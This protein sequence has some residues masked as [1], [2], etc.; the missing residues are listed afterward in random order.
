MTQPALFALFQKRI[1][2]DDSLLTLAQRLFQECGLL[3]EIHAG[4]PEEYQAMLAFH[5]FPG[6]EAMVHL[7]RDLDLLDTDDRDGIVNLAAEGAETIRGLVV[8]DQKAAR[9]NFEAY[10]DAL[11]DL[12]R[13]LLRKKTPVRL[14]VEYAVGLEPDQFCSV[15]EAAADLPAISACIDIG[16]VGIRRARQVYELRFPGHRLTAHEAGDPET[17][18]HLAEVE[19]AV[20]SAMAVTLDMIRRLSALNKPLHFHLHDGH[21]LVENHYHVPDHRSFLDRPRLTAPDDS[22]IELDTL[23]GPE[24]LHAVVETARQH[25]EEEKLT[26]TLEIHETLEALQLDPQAEFL[27]AHWADRTN[28]ERMNHWLD[29]LKRNA[30]LF[31]K[32]WSSRQPEAKAGTTR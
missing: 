23:Y 4:A 25:L 11:R 26:F 24:G 31:Q 27:F 20:L 28:A 19:D 15:I 14:F 17:F 30:N 6:R 2:G 22:R 13:K 7:P 8:H 18:K 5:P 1:P 21:P 16:H 3:P 32:I 9:D 12:N 29:L 10:L